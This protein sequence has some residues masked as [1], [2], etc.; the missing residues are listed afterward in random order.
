MSRTCVH[1]ALTLW[2]VV[3][4]ALIIVFSNESCLFSFHFLVWDTWSCTSHYF[5]LAVKREYIRPSFYSYEVLNIL[6]A[7]AF[8]VTYYFLNHWM[9]VYHMHHAISPTAFT[10]PAFI[11]FLPWHTSH[12]FGVCGRSTVGEN[13]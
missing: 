11:L 3:H 12:Q 7:L 2:A 1:Y 13:R 5:N 8:V 9:C 10:D 4:I 6:C